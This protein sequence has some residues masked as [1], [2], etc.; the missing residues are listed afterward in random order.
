M[1]RV[2]RHTTLQTLF[3]SWRHCV[4]HDPDFSSL[5]VSLPSWIRLHDLAYAQTA[6]QLCQA[7]PVQLRKPFALRMPC[8]IYESLAEE[9]GRVY[10]SEGLNGLWRRLKA[11]LPRHR[12]KRPQVPF[13]IDLQ[14]HFEGLEAGILQSTQDY[15]DSCVQGNRAEIA[16]R[17][18]WQSLDLRASNT[19]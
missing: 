5:L 1:R 13:D 2:R 16:Q 17:Q 10:T 3:R 14:T 11:V 4:H 9:S 6:H 15:A 8:T 19:C 18:P 12:E 7:I